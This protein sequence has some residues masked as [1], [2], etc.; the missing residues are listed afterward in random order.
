[1]SKLH[2]R[3]ADVGTAQQRAM[4]DYHP[5][6]TP[7]TPMVQPVAIMTYTTGGGSLEMATPLITAN[8]AIIPA[9]APG[10]FGHVPMAGRS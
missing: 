6:G 7:D 4:G 2:R 5:Y 8:G 1:M 3:I 10:Y 9:V